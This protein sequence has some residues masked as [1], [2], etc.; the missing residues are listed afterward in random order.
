MIS[1][2]AQKLRDAVSNE[3]EDAAKEPALALLLSTITAIHDI[4]TALEDIAKVQ[5]VTANRNV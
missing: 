2:H 3:D 5:I 1:D 4:A